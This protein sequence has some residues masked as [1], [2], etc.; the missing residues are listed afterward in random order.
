MKEEEK[1]IILRTIRHGEGDLIVHGLTRQ[2]AK[3][4]FFAKSAVQ[5]RKRFGGGTLE[6]THYVHI[7]FQRS[8]RE[9]G[10][11]RL[12]EAQ[13]IKTF[14]GLRENYERIETA[15]YFVAVVERLSHEGII[16][17]SPLFDLLGHSLEAAQK[18]RQ[19]EIL[20]LQFQTKLLSLQ[21]VLPQIEGIETLL[22]SSVRDHEALYASLPSKTSRIQVE[23]S[24]EKLLS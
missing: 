11:H 7:Q 15:L 12:T 16:D 9:G 5:S 19:L 13:L 4:S 21:G 1:I 3:M 18:S 20:K 14:D 17:F 22:V 10:L 24:L 8:T 6:P 2:G 23:K